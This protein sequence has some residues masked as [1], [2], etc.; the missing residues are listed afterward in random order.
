MF[1]ASASRTAMSVSSSWSRV[2]RPFDH[3]AVPIGN[4][5]EDTH[6][7]VH[8]DPRRRVTHTGLDGALDENPESDYQ[9]GPAARD[10]SCEDTGSAFGDQSLQ[11]AG[12]LVDPDSADPWAG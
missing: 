2:R 1:S 3:L 8:S 9:P 5:G 4:S 11:A 6:T 10:S 7:C 12:A